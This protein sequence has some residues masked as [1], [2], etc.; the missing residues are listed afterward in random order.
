MLEDR[1]EEF[2]EQAGC[3]GRHARAGY[4]AL[5]V[6]GGVAEGLFDQ[7]SCVS[8]RLMCITCICGCNNIVAEVAS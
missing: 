4:G 8:L 1:H 6:E 3:E 5:L 7:V 2:D